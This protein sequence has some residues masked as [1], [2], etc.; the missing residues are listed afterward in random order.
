MQLAALRVGDVA[1][2]AIDGQADD[3]RRVAIEFRKK[4]VV[5]GELIAADGAPVGWIK[6]QHDRPAAKMMEIDLLI[7]RGQKLKVGR[8]RAGRQEAGWRIIRA[9]MIGPMNVAGFHKAPPCLA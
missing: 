8:L 6:D 4:L 7:R 3:L 5:Q 1:P 2:D 9:V